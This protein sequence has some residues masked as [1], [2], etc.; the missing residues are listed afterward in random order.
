MRAARCGAGAGGARA[1]AQRERPDGWEL[2]PGEG[3]RCGCGTSPPPS[4]W[5]SS[6]PPAAGPPHAGAA[7]PAGRLRGTWGGRGEDVGRTWG[8]PVEAPWLTRSR[9]VWQLQP[10]PARGGAAPAGAAPD[11]RAQQPAKLRLR[12]RGAPTRPPFV[13]T[14]APKSRRGHQG[15]DVPLR[16]WSIFQGRGY[17][18]WRR[19][20]R[21]SSCGGSAC[22]R[23]RKQNEA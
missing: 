17:W 1:R 19:G 13:H 12:H 11:A 6:S 2:R 3:C 7:Q 5:P 10:G 22:R 20:T 23:P 16:S 9:R 15:P 4:A 8:G 21:P 18:P 14:H